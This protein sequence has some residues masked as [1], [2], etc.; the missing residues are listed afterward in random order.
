MVYWVLG[1]LV[2]QMLLVGYYSAFERG[3]DHAG[4]DEYVLAA[5]L[6]GRVAVARVDK[7]LAGESVIPLP[8]LRAHW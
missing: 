1:A 2:P 3:I 6:S 5:D 7:L 8:H 4:R